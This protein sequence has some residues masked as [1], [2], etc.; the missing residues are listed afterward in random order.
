MN[1]PVV[2]ISISAEELD[3]TGV[4]KFLSEYYLR[5]YI[6]ADGTDYRLL[7]LE[8]KRVFSKLSR[9]FSSFKVIS[10]IN[11]RFDSFPDA[12]LTR[13]ALKNPI[14][15][16]RLVVGKPQ[17]I[18]IIPGWVWHGDSPGA[19]NAWIDGEFIGCF[20]ADRF[21]EDLLKNGV[22]FGGFGFRIRPPKKYMDAKVHHVKIASA[23]AD[24]LVFEERV[25]LP[26]HFDEQRMWTC[27]ESGGYLANA[28]EVEA[29]FYRLRDEV[30]E[31]NDPD[32]FQR[33]KEFVTKHPSYIFNDFYLHER[34]R[35]QGVITPRFKDLLDQRWGNLFDEQLCSKQQRCCKRL[36]LSYNDSRSVRAHSKEYC[37]DEL[38]ECEKIIR[39]FASKTFTKEYADKMSVDVPATLGLIRTIDDFDSFEF[40]SRFVFKPVFGSGVGLYLMH[41]GVNL[42]NGRRY[43][44]TDLRNKFIQSK[45]KNR[46]SVFIVEELLVQDGIDPRVPVLPLDYK[47][48]C[49]G[50]KV[51]LLHVDDRNTIS[52]DPLHR[53]QSWFSRDWK[54]AFMTLRDK[55][56]ANQFLKKPDLY[57][58]MLDVAD[59]ISKNVDEYVRVD[60]YA[61][62]KGVRLGEITTWT[63]Q[64]KGFNVYGDRVMSQAYRIFQA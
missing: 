5:G 10:T 15:R 57:D 7:C 56:Q 29:Q 60:L 16:P 25:T 26:F 54:E 1:I 6:W 12:P 53:S 27:I 33:I 45:E 55:E 24:D 3:A 35:K 46:N 9:E 17:T 40:P 34:D 32:V 58:Q 47:F 49:F 31:G 41:E 22:G 61:T 50:G 18:G 28:G 52:R 51:R 44:I 30:L 4:H 59:S 48:H 36:A 23:V 2:C 20:Q 8:N 42:F 14:K 19:V 21:R 39:H 38:F 37:I 63:H 64:G 43:S 62:D 11:A 13:L